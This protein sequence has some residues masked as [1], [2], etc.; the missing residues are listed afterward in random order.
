MTSRSLSE[1][2]SIISVMPTES[3]HQPTLISALRQK[4]PSDAQNTS[5]NIIIPI[6]CAVMVKPKTAMRGVI[7]RDAENG[8]TAA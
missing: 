8:S 5:T 1:D 6:F 7:Q 4:Y 3:V 2:E